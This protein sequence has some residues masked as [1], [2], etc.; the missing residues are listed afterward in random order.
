M[1][2]MP[3]MTE[4]ALCTHPIAELVPYMT[5]DQYGPLVDDIREHGLRTPIVMYEGMVL[6]GRHRARAW[7]D[8]HGNWDVPSTEFKG[9]VE[10]AIAFVRSHN[11]KRRHLKPS[12][13]AYYEAQAAAFS[14]PQ[15]GRPKRNSRKFPTQRQIAKE[16]GVDIETIAL[17]AKAVRA[18][19][20]VG[21]Y[22]RDGKISVNRALTVAKL[23]EEERLN[24]LTK[25]RPREP[26]KPKSQP[27]LDRHTDAFAEGWCAAVEACIRVVKDEGSY[28]LAAKLRALKQ[29]VRTRDSVRPT[30]SAIETTA[31]PSNRQHGPS[32]EW[33][34]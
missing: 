16:A 26:A 14:N 22:L 2:S 6:D 21:P 34:G 17:A 13:I 29:K 23:P 33:S 7:H 3:L 10:E 31:A 30:R 15:H 20:E 19:P 4:P 12:Q 8:L 24:A 28:R 5:A 1:P 11:I 27:A 32:R 9:T 18:A 25:P